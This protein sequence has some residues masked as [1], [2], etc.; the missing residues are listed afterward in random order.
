[1]DLNLRK[2]MFLLDNL[3]NDISGNKLPTNKQVLRLLFHC[4]K[5]MKTTVYEGC[6]ITIE[7][8]KKFWVFAGIFILDDKRCIKKLESLHEEYR[9]V[10]KNAGIPSNHQKEQEFFLKLEQLFDIAH[11][12]IFEMVSNEIKNFLIDQRSDRNLHLNFSANQQSRPNELSENLLVNVDHFNEPSTSKIPL[13]ENDDSF[14]KLSPCQEIK[15][16]SQSIE[17]ESD[18]VELTRKISNNYLP[19]SSISSEGIMSSGEMISSSSPPSQRSEFEVGGRYYNRKN[20]RGVINIMT[21]NVVATLD[22]CK[23]SYRNSVRIISAISEA[24]QFDVNS[25]ILNK[26]SFNE[27]RKKIREQKAIKIKNLF[28]DV[29]LTAAILHWDGKLIPDSISCKQMD[30]VPILI[31]N[32][33]IEKLLSVPALPN[34]KGITQA[35]EI[36]SVLHDWSL[37]ESIKGLCCDTTASNLGCNNGAAVLLEQ[38]L[39]TDLL[40][41]PCRHHIYELVLTSVFT[42]KLPGTTGPNVPLFKKFQSCWSTIDKS[43]FKDGLEGNKIHKKLISQV[44]DTDYTIKNILGTV[45]PRD[46]Y[47]ELLEL[48]RIFLGTVE[49]QKVN[50][51]K[52]GA[53]HHARWMAKAIYSLKIYIFRDVFELT[54]EEEKSL[55][56]V[57]LFVVFVY[58]RFWFTAPLAVA[59]PNQDLQFVKT[60]YAYRTV[61]KGVSEAVLKK[62]T[63]HFWY[64][65]PEVVAF[66]F[67]DENISVHI[68]RKMIRALKLDTT[69]EFGCPKKYF[70]NN[71]NDIKNLQ[72]KEIDYFVNCHTLG[73]FKRFGISEDF[74]ETEVETWYEN[75]NYLKGL[76]IVK[77]IKVVNDIAERAVQLT[78]DYVN[79]LAKDESQKQYLLH[80]I[81]EYKNEFPNAT[82]ECL[83]KKMKT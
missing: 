73:F 6:K 54:K 55:L 28:G 48:S 23:V 62:I 72:T 1:M 53:F 9:M 12:R 34:G 81:K 30:R 25:L 58:V 43:K 74:L 45:L 20:E 5:N 59:A 2:P 29:Q 46:D 18:N 82:K 70:I 8:V 83:T 4:T 19:S 37:T 52:P 31:S 27:Q 32:S 63:N 41:L 13:S 14:I 35:E 33:G 66:A 49:H 56:D 64:L 42:L 3:T 47:K 21:E 68:K 65:S 39:E 24:L 15:T 61:D 57:C 10:H 50:F 44:D 22:N 67:F 77:N 79:V 36:Y 76:E 71:D 80:V 69:Y 38:M 17:H 60:V 16:I 51:Y 11:S 78:Q 75:D 26:T 40:W 7:K